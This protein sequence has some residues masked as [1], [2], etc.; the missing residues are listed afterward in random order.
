MPVVRRTLMILGLVAGL[1]AL[2]GCNTFYGFGQDMKEG[3][4][5]LQRATGQPASF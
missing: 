2:S 3:G 5:A 1:A 4:R